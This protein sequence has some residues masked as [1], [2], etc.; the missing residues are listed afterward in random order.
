MGNDYNMKQELDNKDTQ[1]RATTCAAGTEITLPN[2]CCLAVAA[3]TDFMKSDSDRSCKVIQT[4]TG[5]SHTFEFEPANMVNSMVYPM[6]CSYDP[7][8]RKVYFNENAL[9]GSTGVSSN[10]Q[11]CFDK[12][13]IVQ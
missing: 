9:G 4:S 12:I 7:K 6:G 13:G 2:E 3:T 8:T 5:T 10:I 11:V 1:R